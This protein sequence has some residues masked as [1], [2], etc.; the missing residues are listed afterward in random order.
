MPKKSPM[1]V[2]QI[3]R[4]SQ[5]RRVQGKHQSCGIPHLR[6]GY[7]RGNPRRVDLCCAAVRDALDDVPQRQAWYRRLGREADGNGAVAATARDGEVDNAPWLHLPIATAAAATA[8]AGGVAAA[9]AVEQ[10]EPRPP[11]VRAVSP[12]DVTPTRTIRNGKCLQQARKRETQGD[13]QASATH[14]LFGGDLPTL[15]FCGNS[16]LSYEQP[17]FG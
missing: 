17:L 7:D 15:T 14:V 12:S 16:P 2:E 11:T 1:S 13:K 10:E 9:A 4:S 8:A 5:E 3:S 6:G